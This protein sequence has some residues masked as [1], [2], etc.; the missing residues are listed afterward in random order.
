MKDELTKQEVDFQLNCIRMTN[1]ERRLRERI[2]E[3]YIKGY[4]QGL[5]DAKEQQEL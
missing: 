1:S 2:Q 3:I 5:K 4:E